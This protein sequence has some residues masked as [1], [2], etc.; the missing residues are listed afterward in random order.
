MTYI[1]DSSEGERERESVHCFIIS[2]VPLIRVPLVHVLF[3]LV[4]DAI[5][6]SCPQMCILFLKEYTV[7]DREHTIASSTREK[8]TQ[9]GQ[10]VHDFKKCTSFHEKEYTISKKST[11]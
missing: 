7:G 8:N 1:G 10:R 6:C 2:E 3:S 5:V 11:R 9:N 4:E